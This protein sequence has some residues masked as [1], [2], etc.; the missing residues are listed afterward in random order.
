MLNQKKFDTKV[1]EEINALKPRLTQNVTLPFTPGSDG[2]LLGMIRANASGRVY[3]LVSNAYP[4]SV[5]GYTVA[6]GYIQNALFVKKG[7]TV[8]QTDSANLLQQLW[9]FVSLD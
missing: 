9:W 5:D 4:S 7:N 8:S 1:A 2:L 6:K 3:I